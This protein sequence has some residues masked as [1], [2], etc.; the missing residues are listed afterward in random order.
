M[1]FGDA[2]HTIQMK[3]FFK[4]NSRDKFGLPKSYRCWFFFGGFWDPVPAG[5]VVLEQ[6]LDS[7]KLNLK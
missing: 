7:M 5:S 3:G 6:H 4:K 2:K 1:F